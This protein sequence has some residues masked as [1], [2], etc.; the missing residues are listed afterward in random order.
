VIVGL[1]A[2]CRVLFK[3]GSVE[4]HK[5]GALSGSQ[6]KACIDLNL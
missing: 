2:A 1:A 5:T 6:L 4:A 3:L